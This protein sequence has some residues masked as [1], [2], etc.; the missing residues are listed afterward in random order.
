MF[1]FEKWTHEGFSSG[2]SEK[3]ELI[4]LTFLLECVYSKQ[5]GIFCVIADYEA[6]FLCITANTVLCI[7]MI[8]RGKP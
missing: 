6:W 7:Y 4:F 2:D 3:K 5:A 8:V 1:R